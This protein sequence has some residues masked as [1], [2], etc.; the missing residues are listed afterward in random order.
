MTDTREKG[1]AG[2]EIA[3]KFLIKNGFKIEDR[4]YYKKWGELDIIATKENQLGNKLK[5]ELHFFEVKS[6][7]RN[8]TEK[9]FKNRSGFHDPE[10]NVHDF[11]VKQLRK[12]IQTYLVDKGYGL[13]HIFN[14]HILCVYM[15]EKTR[16]ARVKWVNNV[17][18]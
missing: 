13:N 1:N 12:I 14:F 6:V 17:I 2:E 5:K 18:L 15:N 16:K 10:E 8:F 7:V 3:C 9:S 11:K 4:N